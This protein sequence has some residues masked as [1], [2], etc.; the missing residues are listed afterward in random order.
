MSFTKKNKGVQTRPSLA[1]AHNLSEAY[2]KSHQDVHADEDN[3]M[4]ELAELFKI[5]ISK[6]KKAVSSWTSDELMAEVLAF[7]EFCA[8][9]SIKPT[10]GTLGLFLGVT[11]STYNVWQN[12]VSRYGEISE[13]INMA[14]DLIA[15]QYAS[16]GE[17]Y[18]TMNMFLLKAAHGYYEKSQIDINTTGSTVTAEDIAD[19]IKLMGLNS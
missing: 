6:R 16:R 19:K 8:K 15:G 17:K 1:G 11:T 13:I 14:N 12:D 4:A 5:C 10:K 2:I 18:P 7:F 3:L 9:R